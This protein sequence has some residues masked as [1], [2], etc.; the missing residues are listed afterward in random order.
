MVKVAPTLV[1]CATWMVPGWFDGHWFSSMN[2]LVATWGIFLLP[3]FPSFGWGVLLQS[4]HVTGIPPHFMHWVFGVGPL[5]SG[6]LAF[7]WWW[8]VAVMAWVF[9]ARAV[10]AHLFFCCCFLVL[11]ELYFLFLAGILFPPCSGP[12]LPL[13]YLVGDVRLLPCLWRRWRGIGVR[14]W[15]RRLA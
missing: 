11:F 12:V 13:L 2:L 7:H 10:S 8:Q 9:A 14:A 3:P 1:S 6:I 4:G 5:A 15:W